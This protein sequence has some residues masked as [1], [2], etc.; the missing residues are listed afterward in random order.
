MA[1]AALIFFLSSESE[2]PQPSTLAGL[3]G[4]SNAAHFGLY[5]VL[6]ALLYRAFQGAGGREQGAGDKTRTTGTNPY[7][8]AFVAGALY[9]ASD[10]VHQY[11]VPMRQTDAVDWLVDIAG[12][13]VGAL[14]MRVWERRHG[15]S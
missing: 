4:W 6:G 5:L 9:A 8:L 3:P 12:V 1:W 2:P 7:L 14:A 10:E 15:K 11:F 13:L